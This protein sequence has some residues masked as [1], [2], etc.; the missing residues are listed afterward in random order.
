[1][2]ITIQT[3]IPL[4]EKS[5]PIIHSRSAKYPFKH[6]K[7]GDSFLYSE[8]PA[9]KYY[10]LADQSIRYWNRKFPERKFEMRRYNQTIRVWRTI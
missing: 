8:D 6:M 3:K 2:G 4:P 7:V 10:K 1:M 5:D 9:P